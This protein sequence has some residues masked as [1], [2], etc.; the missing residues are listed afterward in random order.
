M[1]SICITLLLIFVSQVQLFG[2]GW[3]D[4][5]RDIGDGYAIVHCNV[6]QHYIASEEGEDIYPFN[7]DG[8]GPIK[9]YQVTKKYIFANYYGRISE[10]QLDKS[11]DYYFIIDKEKH[12]HF[13]PFS[14]AEF[15]ERAEVKSLPKLKWK[16]P[17]NPNLL[18]PVL[19]DIF[20][21]LIGTIVT[22]IHYYEI[23]IPLLIISL[24]IMI[25]LFLK[26]RISWRR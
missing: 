22:F 19:G 25:Y 3:H 1:K 18:K 8:V 10:H 13:G 23:T 16:K 21:L 17:K 26:I 24:L 12:E 2:F 6:M 14:E 4:Y 7:F 9:L 11:K 15:L 20:F 5:T